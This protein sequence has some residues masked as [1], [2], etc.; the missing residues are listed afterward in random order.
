METF[1]ESEWLHLLFKRDQL[2]VSSKSLKAIAALEP[3][4][5]WVRNLGRALN[6]I[7]LCSALDNCHFSHAEWDKSIAIRLIP[8]LQ[9][10]TKN[11]SRLQS[12]CVIETP[13]RVTHWIFQIYAEAKSRVRCCLAT[14]CQVNHQIIKPLEVLLF[15]SESAKPSL[16]F[17]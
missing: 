7:S 1:A 9:T 12:C 4:A 5:E 11:F 17:I 8:T 2:S 13:S 3:G 10:D 15:G 14:W 6:C 16:G